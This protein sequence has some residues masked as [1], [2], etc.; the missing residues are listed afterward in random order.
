VSVR[1]DDEL[2]DEG[3]LRRALRLDASEMPDP[4][5]ASAIIAL[6][7]RTRRAGEP[8]VSSALFGAVAGVLVAFAAVASAG[9]LF[10]ALAPAG[11]AAL[12]AVLA[13]AAVIGETAAQALQDPTIPIATLA[14]ITVAIAYEHR[15]R[16]ERANAYRTA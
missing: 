13:R 6:A 7:E 16:R 10:P 4:L 5:D 8:R 12:L 1:S 11:F 15:L 9:A 3:R 2:F 14:G